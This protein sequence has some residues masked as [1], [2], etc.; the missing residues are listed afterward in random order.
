MFLL[1]RTIYDNIRYLLLQP[2][3]VALCL[4]DAEKRL[5]KGI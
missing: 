1:H 4:H 5:A 2:Y 3:F